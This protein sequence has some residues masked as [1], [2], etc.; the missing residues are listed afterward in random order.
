[1]Q[2]REKVTLPYQ[3]TS[4]TG[5]IQAGVFSLFDVSNNSQSVILQP[6]SV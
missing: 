5:K 4:S 6:H 1:M 2:R 3:E